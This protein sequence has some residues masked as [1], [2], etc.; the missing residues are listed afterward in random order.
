VERVALI[1]AFPKVLELDGKARLPNAVV[2]IE[3]D[4]FLVL[5]LI[6]EVFRQ[7]GQARERSCTHV[8]SSDG[9][10]KSCCIKLRLCVRRDSSLSLWAAIRL[11][12]ELR[13]VAMRYC[14][15]ASGTNS[16]NSL[17]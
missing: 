11:S 7:R 14:S 4:V 5:Q 9:F 1:A 2:G 16:S 6:A 15:C 10:G 8:S 17:R 12:S 13:Q 3:K